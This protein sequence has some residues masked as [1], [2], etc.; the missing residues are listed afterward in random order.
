MSIGAPGTRIEGLSMWRAILMLGGV[1]LH[2]A[3]S[4]E[5]I[6][7]FAAI[8]LI[9]HAFR[10]GSFMLIS[11]LLCGYAMARRRSPLAWLGRRSI[12]IGVPLLVGLLVICPLIGWMLDD[13][14]DRT[15]WPFV[16]A[17]DWYHLWFLVALLAYA[18]LSYAFHQWDR[19]YGV[20]VRIEQALADRSIGSGRSAQTVVL[21]ATALA[22]CALVMLTRQ[23]L[24]GHIP[25]GYAAPLSHIQLMLGYAPFYLLGFL[26]AR[27]PMLFRAATHSIRMPVIILV[28]VGIVYA[29]W[30][31]GVRL[32]LDPLRRAIV[33]DLVE[34][35]GMAICPPAASVLILRSAITIRTI[36]T[37]VRRFA[38]ASFT[39]YILHFPV[40]IA[41]KLVLMHI[42]WNPYVEFSI[43]I[44]AASAI[45]YAAHFLAVERF[46]LMSFLLN[47]R[48]PDSTK[49]TEAVLV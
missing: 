3:I 45:T 36:P 11:G 13:L 1:L 27:S 16:L 9:S 25:P 32:A 22:C 2:G 31:G 14:P 24:A 43:T 21:L 37:I 18:P 49:Q 6:P 19:R 47:G 12:Q 38:D 7:V 15:R 8:P 23:I 4:L 40:I 10:M 46:P 34:L 28:C 39:I 29:G 33:G 41:A 26:L 35:I 48:Y 5:H 30:F 44:V 17:H 42:A 20:I